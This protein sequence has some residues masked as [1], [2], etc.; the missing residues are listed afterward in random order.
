MIVG[1][2]FYPRGSPAM[3]QARAHRPAMQAASSRLHRRIVLAFA[4]NKLSFCIGTASPPSGGYC[5]RP[6]CAE[7][8]GHAIGIAG[9]VI[10]RVAVAVDQAEIRGVAG[11]RRALPPVGC[12][13]DGNKTELNPCCLF[14]RNSGRP[15]RQ[16]LVPLPVFLPD[17]CQQLRFLRDHRAPLL[18]GLPNPFAPFRVLP[19]RLV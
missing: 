1:C 3:K 19:G 13:A 7:S 16:I 4:G 15:V 2:A 9:V 14:F 11:I 18:H 5:V 8:E 10:V 6:C 17:S 12:R